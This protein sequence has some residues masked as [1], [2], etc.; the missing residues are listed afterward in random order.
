MKKFKALTADIKIIRA[1]KII[2]I[3][4]LIPNAISS[5]KNSSNIAL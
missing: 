2:R 3:K 5:D 1:L 4:K